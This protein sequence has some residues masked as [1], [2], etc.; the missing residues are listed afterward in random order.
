MK[1][2]QAELILEKINRLYKTMALDN[3]IN[4]FE[5]DLMLSYIRQLH[6][7]FSAEET[8]KEASKP[9]ALPVAK[10]PTPSSPKSKPRQ[11]R[12]W[13]FPAIK[14][15]EHF[16][17]KTTPKPKAKKTPKTAAKKSRPATAKVRP[18]QVKAY[19]KPAPIVKA[20]A[21]KPIRFYG[22]LSKTEYEALFDH[23]DAMELEG[24]SAKMPIKD[25][26]KVMGSREKTSTISQ[27]FDGDSKSFDATIKTLNA[28]N[29]YGQAKSYLADE[30]ASKYDW[31]NKIRKEKTSA[32]IALVRRRYK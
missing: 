7:T 25:L 32:F 13:S 20:K 24:M 16:V 19:K 1:I 30:I 2:K 23:R 15:S 26:A 18:P 9:A 17:K 3:K 31:P 27:L 5:R 28:F 22:S 21:P 6:D 11:R 14:I 10:K 29:T 12:R 8:T 4:V